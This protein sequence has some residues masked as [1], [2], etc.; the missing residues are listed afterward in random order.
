MNEI[1]VSVSKELIFDKKLEK[2]D[3]PF[4]RAPFLPHLTVFLRGVCPTK[5]N[6]LE[7]DESARMPYWFWRS[8]NLR[9]VS[10]KLPRLN[11]SWQVEPQTRP[12]QGQ[13]QPGCAI[14]Q[15]RAINQE[16]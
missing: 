14:N 9:L 13:A 5:W 15:D 6:L 12:G 16:R 1:S 3:A 7:S 2:T 10:V 8:V 11:K 4:S